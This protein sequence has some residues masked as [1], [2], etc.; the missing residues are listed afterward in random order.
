MLPKSKKLRD[1]SRPDKKQCDNGLAPL[2]CTCV[3][4]CMNQDQ[5]TEDAR[6]FALLVYAG[7]YRIFSVLIRSSDDMNSDCPG[8]F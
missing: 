2:L 3:Y 4:A 1:E 5:C 8:S 7:Y 6:F